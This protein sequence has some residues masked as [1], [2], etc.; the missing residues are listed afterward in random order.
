MEIDYAPYTSTMT[1]EGKKY[2]GTIS[3][4]GGEVP[5]TGAKI[6]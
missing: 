6:D 2:T 1:I 3:A 5:V 4:D